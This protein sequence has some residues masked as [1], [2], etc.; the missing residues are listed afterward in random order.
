ML[1]RIVLNEELF[2]EF[3]DN[4]IM[5]VKYLVYNIDEKLKEKYSKNCCDNEP[6]KSNNVISCEACWREFL[7]NDLI[8][9]EDYY[10]DKTKV[11]IADKEISEYEKCQNAIDNNRNKIT[12]MLDD[13][14]ITGPCEI[15]IITKK[16]DKQHKLKGESD[17]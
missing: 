6:N 7:T 16:Y 3:K 9:T 14:E 11:V 15:S 12:V 4:V 2:K 1:S 10:L 13:K 5:C 8:R 17:S